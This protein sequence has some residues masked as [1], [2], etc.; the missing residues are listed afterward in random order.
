[1]TEP[2]EL[3]PVEAG[4]LPDPYERTYMAGEGTVL[5]RDKSRAPW[6]LHALFG[7]AALTVITA[8]VLAGQWLV[9]AFALPVITVV[10][11]FLSV[12]RVTVSQG[13]VQV[14]YGLFGPTIPIAQVDAVMPVSYDWKRFGGWGI[15]RSIEGTWIYNMPGDG[16]RAVQVDWHDA[17]GR[18]RVTLIGS[19]RAEQLAQSIT[20]ARAALPAS[21]DRPALAPGDDEDE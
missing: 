11:L 16:G 13:A 3:V 21:A 10:W 8:N 19:R 14:Q 4:K 6:G 20:Q 17:R 12:L 1:V 9:L 15:R 2:K 7:L 18:K 5:Y